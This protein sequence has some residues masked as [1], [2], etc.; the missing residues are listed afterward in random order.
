MK[1]PVLR[2]VLGVMAILLAVPGLLAA[3]DYPVANPYIATIAGTPSEFMA[4]LPAGIRVKQLQLKVFE[5][6]DVPPVFWY[7]KKLKYSLAWQKE[8]AP[9]I[10]V[11]AAAGTGYNAPRMQVLQRAFFKAG[12]HVVCLP[13][14]THPN[15]IVTAST[16]GVPGNVREDASDLYRVMT[17]IREDLQDRIE[18]SEFFLTGYSLGGAETAF[19][20]KLDEEK[21]VFNFRKVLMINPP[22][23]LY[24]SIRILDQMLVRNVPGGLDNLN[25]FIDRVMTKF[26][27]V[28]QKLDTLDF[29]NNVLYQV[30][31][32]KGTSDK[33]MAA[34]IGISF[35]LISSNMIIT[36]DVFNNAG[37]LVPKNHILSSTDSTTDYLKVAFRISFEKYFDE[38]FYPFFKA[39]SPGLTK[40]ALI[41][42]VSLRSIEKYLASTEKIGVIA[43]EDDLILAPGELDYLRQVF[44]KRAKIYPHGGHLGNI[45][46]RENVDYMLRFFSERGE[47]P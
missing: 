42:S 30:F 3:Y 43:N 10:F 44:G 38:F 40:E 16:T 32:E 26:S 18:V 17:Q 34:L 2:S 8:K 45:D 31:E 46:Y 35:R 9:L 4:E 11:I 39:R 22:V 33:E 1:N 29:N 5:D 41:E 7:Q 6:R 23:S 27:G 15:F 25:A 24:S 12:F 20:A 21:K 13:S 19:L 37:Y 28:Y 14:P 36:A 47:E